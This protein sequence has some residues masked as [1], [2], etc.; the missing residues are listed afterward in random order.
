LVLACV[1]ELGRS[2]ELH[3]E[4]KCSETEG[5]QQT[6]RKVHALLRSFCI[7]RYLLLPQRKVES[8][9]VLHTL[10]LCEIWSFGHVFVKLAGFKDLI[11]ALCVPCIRLSCGGVTNSIRSS[12]VWKPK[13]V[14]RRLERSM[15]CWGHFESWGT[16]YCHKGK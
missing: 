3:Q 5:R 9:S 8:L 6:P 1:R 2:N 12:S 11:I 10:V 13:A 15:R 4:I 16:C 7:L 14:S